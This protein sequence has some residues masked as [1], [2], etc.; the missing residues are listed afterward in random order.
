M[1]PPGRYLVSASLSALALFAGFG[2]GA[3][4][5]APRLDLSGRPT[6]DIV[7]EA[8]RLLDR[9]RPE[10]A[11]RRAEWVLR[12]RFEDPLA[13]EARRMAAEARLAAGDAAQAVVHL[14]RLM[15]E[16]P[17]RGRTPWVEETLWKIGRDLVRQESRWFDDFAAAHDTGVEALQLLVVRF[18]HGERADDAWKE[19]GLSFEREGRWRAAIDVFERLAAEYPES[20]WADLALFRAAEDYR[21]LSGGPRFDVEPFLLAEAAARRYLERFP[22]GNHVEEAR[23][24]LAEVRGE[25]AR[26]EW[27]VAEYYRGLGDAEGERVR[28][29]NLV[30]RFPDTEAGKKARARL[31]RLG[32]DPSALEGSVE[33]LRPSRVRPPWRSGPGT[34]ESGR[35]GEARGP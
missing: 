12:H 14:R 8:R 19:L 32:V 6:A 7:R 26:H 22:H 13:F 31:R 9:G 29:A 17:I 34:E 30:R 3:T 27:S 28:L 23:R 25:I 11:A 2:C 5:P 10:E 4:W 21:R 33:R 15:D 16:H 18:P 35:G 20:E 1:K 24:A